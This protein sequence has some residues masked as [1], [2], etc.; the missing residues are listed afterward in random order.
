M[1]VKGATACSLQNAD[2][3]PPNVTFWNTLQWRHNRHDSVSNHL[4][5]DCLL[6]RLFKRIS[7]NTSKLCVSVFF[8][9]FFF[10]GG[11]GG[12]SPVT[13]KFPSQRSS[14]AENLSIWCRHH[15]WQNYLLPGQ[16]LIV[17]CISKD[18]AM[19]HAK[20]RH[21]KYGNSIPICILLTEIR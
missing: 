14:K 21:A 13:G 9:F 20:M 18:H 4:R 11:A 7:N 3:Y 12:D 5:L 16:Y 17:K 10:L 19:Y 1:L 2:L 8:F 6:N 15:V